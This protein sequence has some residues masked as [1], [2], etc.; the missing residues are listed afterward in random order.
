MTDVLYMLEKYETALSD[1]E[2]WEGFKPLAVPL[3][4]YD[5]TNTYLW[6][7][8]SP[9]SGFER[10]ADAPNVWRSPGRYPSIV[11]NSVA[12]INEVD[13]ATVFYKKDEQH[14]NIDAWISLL[15][16]EAF[17]I[18][19]RDFLKGRAA[20]EADLF[21][22]PFDDVQLLALAQTGNLCAS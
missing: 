20:N 18:Y 13:T 9:P 12:E 2:L 19:Q 3:A 6:S 15:A 16:H 5:G 7:H 1:K 8:P 17:H 4:V 10:L 21:L 11:A 22:Y 14:Q